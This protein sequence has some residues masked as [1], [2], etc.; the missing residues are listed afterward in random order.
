MRKIVTL[1]L[2]FLTVSLAKP[3]PAAPGPGIPDSWS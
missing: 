1:A 3:G 2:V